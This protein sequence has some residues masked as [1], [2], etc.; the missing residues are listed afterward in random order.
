M[1]DIPVF[2]FTA[3]RANYFCSIQV[4]IYIQDILEV[5][6]KKNFLQVLSVLS[7]SYSESYE[8]LL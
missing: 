3:A 1:S 2:N 5:S 8:I 4:E 7:I 6:N